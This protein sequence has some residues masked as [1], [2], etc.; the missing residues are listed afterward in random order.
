VQVGSR[1][2]PIGT[3]PRTNLVNAC[4]EL[5]RF[6]RVSHFDADSQSDRKLVTY[7]RASCSE[8]V[9]VGLSGL[10][11][12]HVALPAVDLAL[13]TDGV[14]SA[15]GPALPISRRAAARLRFRCR[16]ALYTINRLGS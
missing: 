11:K 1:S 8:I 13:L 6:R 7:S 5:S 9:F 16:T 3:P 14:E 10:E 2:A 4:K 12:P 15:S